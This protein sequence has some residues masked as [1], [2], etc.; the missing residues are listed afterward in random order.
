MKLTFKGWR[1]E[2]KEHDHPVEPVDCASGGYRAKTKDQP[3]TWSG[4]LTA[5]GKVSGLG[6]SGDFLVEFT[7]EE[8]EL[9]NW[10]EQYLKAKPEEALRMIASLHAEAI[11]GLSKQSKSE[12][13]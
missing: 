13:V 7:F 11:I 9:G 5:F 10:F 4:P 12:S 1:R 3:L 2:A 8:R 6:L